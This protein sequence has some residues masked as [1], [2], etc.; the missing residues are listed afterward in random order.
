V[1]RPWRAWLERIEGWPL[2]AAVEVGCSVSAGIAALAAWTHG[3]RSE[4]FG[5]MVSI[6]DPLRPLAVLAVLLVARWSAARHRESASTELAA[7]L[8]RVIAGALLV[9]G[10]LAWA[11]YMSPYV[12]GADSYGYISAAERLRSLALVQREALADAIPNPDAAIPLAYVPKPGTAGVSVPAY[13]LGLPAVMA[14]AAS[15]FGERAP[16]AVSFVC[17]VVLVAVCFWLVHHWTRDRTVA[18]A[19][20]AAVSFH[21]VVFTYA[22]QPLSD[23]PAAM[24]FLLAAALLIDERPSRAALGG[25]AAGMALLT[26]TAQLPG[27]A[28]LILVPFVDGSKRMTRAAAFIAALTVGV[29]VQLG[30]QWY[31]YG[32]PLANGYGS[33]S[34]LFGLRFLAANV[35]SYAHVGLVT[36]GP[37]WIGGAVVALVICRAPTARAIALAAAIGAALPYAVYRTYDHW[38]T[39][40]FILPLLVVG[41]MFFAIGLAS[42]ARWLLGIGPGT[43]VAVLL[44]VAQAWSWARWLDREQILDLARS[45]ERFAQAGRLVARITPPDAVIL[46]SLHSGSLRY[47]AHRLTIDWGKIPPGQFD[48]TLAALQRIDRPVFLMIDGEE[49]RSQFA[50]RHGSV[51]DDHHWLPSGEGRDLLLFRAPSADRFIP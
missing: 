10:V 49:E 36:H 38:E 37:L 3:V 27:C 5:V 12:G 23:V 7:A 22:I 50:L 29:G 46:A 35:R 26:R 34:E 20:A 6:R 16:F 30:L 47:Y 25:V 13:A 45:Q 1:Q 8:P 18:I 17:A 28:A 24:W 42:V 33:A 43:W 2:A 41:T 44:V 21:P 15:L 48:A 39:Q 9:T 32:S 31:L 11:Q 4:L 51:I 40:R 19:A 14:I